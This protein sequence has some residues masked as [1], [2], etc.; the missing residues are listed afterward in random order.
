MWKLEADER[1]AHW[2]AFRLTLG[3]K[4][5]EQ[6]VQA[7]ADFWQNC[8]HKPYYLDPNDAE[9]WPTAWELIT[10]N[11]YCDLAKALGMLYTIAYSRHGHDLPMTLCVYKDAETGYEYNLAMFDEGKYVI[12]LLDGQVV[13][14]NSVNEKFKLKYCYDSTILK[15]K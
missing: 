12:N 8:P 7:T 14:I 13:N 10:E 2:R 15:L 11:Y 4:S 5:L 3:G 1:I 9:N 6:A